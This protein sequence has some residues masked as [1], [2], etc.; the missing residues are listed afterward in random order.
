MQHPLYALQDSDFG[1]CLWCSDLQRRSD[2]KP[3]WDPGWPFEQSHLSCWWFF[4]EHG[5]LHSGLSPFQ[6][7]LFLPWL[8]SF[9]LLPEL[10]LSWTKNLGLSTC[11][12]LENVMKPFRPTSTP[13][14]NPVIGRGSTG[15]ASTRNDTTQVPVGIFLMLSLWTSPSIALCSLI[16]MSPILESQNSP[17]FKEKPDWI[18]QSAHLSGRSAGPGF[19]SSPANPIR[20]L[21]VLFFRFYYPNFKSVI[22]PVE[23]ENFR[24]K[25]MALWLSASWWDPDTL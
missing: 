1:P 21:L 2:H 17:G 24:S 20:E 15:S 18:R 11:S 25:N 3:L 6:V 22:F 12:P 23:K 10:L 14:D 5:E 4:N 16:L 8:A 19:Q 7:F 13:I 9:V